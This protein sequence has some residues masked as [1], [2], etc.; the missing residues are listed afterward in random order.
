MH[1]VLTA[2][3]CSYAGA[4]VW[5]SVS[6]CARSWSSLDALAAFCGGLVDNKIAVTK[7]VDML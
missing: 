3:A 5:A 2:L 4:V 6:E 1:G 7:T